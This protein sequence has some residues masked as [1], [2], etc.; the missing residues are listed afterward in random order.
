MRSNRTLAGCAGAWSLGGALLAW[1]AGGWA[2]EAG[3]QT[4]LRPP[5]HGVLGLS[6]LAT[7]WLWFAVWAVIALAATKAVRLIWNRVF[8]PLARRTRTTLD[9]GVLEATRRPIGFVVCVALLLTGSQLSFAGLPAV[10]GHPAWGIAQG[11]LYIAQVLGVTALLYAAARAFIEWYSSQM[12]AKSKSKL[13]DQFVTLFHKLAKFVFL[14]V[15]LTI[16]FDHFG[17]QIT[18]LLATAGV[19]SLAV[20]FAAQETIANMISGFVLMV[21][22][23]FKPGDRIQFGSGQMGDVLEIGLRSTRVLSFD[24]TV[25]TVPNAE[26]AKAQIVNFNAPDARF[27]IRAPLG[28]AYGSDLRK[29]KAIIL[30]ILNAHPE[31]LKEPAPPSVFFTGFG[32]SSL[33]LM[34]LYWVADY[35]DQF[36][37]R[38]EV[39]MAIKDRFEAEGVEIP[40]PQRDLHIRSTVEIPQPP[41]GSKPAGGSGV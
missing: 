26:I 9:V 32:E 35:R 16:I 38:D 8:L 31:V 23:P 4:M 21:D 11:I 20:A 36:R 2:A 1:P 37:I 22:R 40:F 30:D 27:K 7:G 10:T 15:A 34:L 18:G 5:P 19:M 24:N 13:D 3:P 28:V 41:A 17:I 33:D 12:A 29:V 6:P 25:I 14:F 39:N